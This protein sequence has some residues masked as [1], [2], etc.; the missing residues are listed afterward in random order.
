MFTE[1]M[2]RLHS[3][4]NVNDDFHFPKAHL[5]VFERENIHKYVSGP[6]ANCDVKRVG[7]SFEA[8]CSILNC[9]MA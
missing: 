9:S 3:L 8:L 2:T 7:K 1:R 6:T 4:V 5:A